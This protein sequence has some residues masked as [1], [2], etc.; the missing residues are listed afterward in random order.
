M[1]GFK[2]VRGGV[3]AGG[4]A[5]ELELVANLMRDVMIIL[6]EDPAEA[7]VPDDDPLA[8]LEREMRPAAS[9]SDDPALSRLLPD[10]SEDP[11]MAEEMRNLTEGSV[12]STKVGHLK[13]VY[14]TLDGVDGMFTV[15]DA[16]VPAWLGALNDLRLVL[17]ARL[18][19]DSSEK[20]D[21]VTEK[22][23]DLAEQTEP[24]EDL[25]E[26]E[27]MNNQLSLMYAMISWWQD[28]LIDAMRFHRPRG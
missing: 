13:I 22:A 12:R 20:A 11:E 16:D 8:V 5:M 9:P 26:E 21:A 17:A 18:E 15:K 19:I 1:Y 14:Q 28:S 24:R 4:D 6:G 27:E 2:R 25:S 3:S 7:A 10:M 23:M